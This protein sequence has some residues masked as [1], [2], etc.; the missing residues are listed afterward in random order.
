MGFDLKEFLNLNNKQK[1]QSQPQPAST[2]MPQ[3]SIVSKVVDQVNPFDNGRTFRQATPTNNRSILGQATHNMGTNVL[4]DFVG[5]PFIINPVQNVIETG[6]GISADITNNTSALNASR[7]RQWQNVKSSLPG[8]IVSNIYN[9]GKA[10]TIDLGKQ[11]IGDLTNNPVASQNANTAYMND[12]NRSAIGGLLTIPQRQL[13]QYQTNRDSPQLNDQQR[14]QVT[15]DKLQ[16]VGLDPKASLVNQLVTTGGSAIQLASPTFGLAKTAVEGTP[17]FNGLQPSYVSGATLIDQV[18]NLK[19]VTTNLVDKTKLNEVGAIG[20]D[21]R[22]LDINNNPVVN[23]KTGETLNQVVDKLKKNNWSEKDINN[24][25][26]AVKNPTRYSEI[27]K[28]NDGKLNNLNPTGTIFAEYTPKDRSIQPLGSDM[29]TVDKTIG[30]SPNDMVTVYRGVNKQ[31]NQTGIQPGDFVTTLPDLAKAYAG[32]G[33]VISLKIR[34]GD[35]LDSKSSPSLGEETIYRPGA[36]KELNIT[37]KNQPIVGKNLSDTALQSK[38][39][40]ENSI[41]IPKD[42]QLKTL[43]SDKTMSHFTDGNSPVISTNPN[44]LIPNSLSASNTGINSVFGKNKFDI[45]IPKNSKVLEVSKQSFNDMYIGRLPGEGK[46]PLEVGKAL[47]DHAVS[48]GADVIHLKNPAGM[49][50][51]WAVINKDLLQNKKP[52]I[53]SDQMGAV[54]RNIRQQDTPIVGPDLNVK[55]SR[56]AQ[57]AAK[58]SELSPELQKQIKDSAPTYQGGNNAEQIK[59]ADLLVKKGYVKATTEVTSALEKKMGT[60]TPQDT[61]NTIAVIK[62]LDKRGGTANLQKATDLTDKL[63]EHLTAAGQTVQSASL[64]S[65]RTPEGLLYGARKFLKNNGIDVTAEIQKTLNDHVNAI[66]KLSSD[67]KLNEIAKMQ[68][69]VEHLVP[70]SNL[71]KAIGIWKA[72]LLTG[73]KTQT[74]NMLSGI[75]TNV[76]KTASDAPAALLD[77]GFA[78]FGKTD[79]G[80]KMGFTGD[81]A[82]VFTMRGKGAGLVEGI[83]KGANAL[84][85]GIDE[86]NLEAGK[87]D[88]KTLVFSKKPLGRI[89]QKYTDSVYGLMGAADRPNYYSNL[90]NNLYDLALVDGKNKG[91]SGAELK[92]HV[93]DFVSNPPTKDFQTATNAAEKAIFANDTQL[94]KI[95]GGVRKAAEGNVVSKTTAGVLMPFTKVPSAVAMRIV[96][97]SPLGALKTVGEQIKNV[98]KGGVLDQRALSEGLAQAGVGTGAIWLGMQLKKN[99]LMTGSYPTDPKEQELWK[100]EGKQANSVKVNGQWQSIN[101]TSPAGQVLELGAKMQDAKGQGSSWGDTALTGAFAIPK[102][103][104]EQ[105]FLQGVQGALDATNDPGRYGSKFLKS[106]AAST[107]PTFVGDIAKS[108]DPL[109]RQSNSL[110]DAFKAKIPGLNKTLLPKQDAF[111]YPL[112]RQSSSVNTLANPFRPS[113][114]KPTTD[115]NTELRRL[116]DA[117]YGVMPTTTDKTLS[118]GSKDKGTLQNIN[119]TPKQLFDKNSQV[120][121]IVKNNWEKIIK[122]PEY[123]KMSDSEKQKVLR[124]VLSDANALGKADFAAK[125]NPALLDKTNLNKN[126][127]NLAQGNAD[128]LKTKTTEKS[129]KPKTVKTTKTKSISKSTGSK[130]SKG[131]YNFAK[132][133]TT[134]V[135]SSSELRNIVKSSKI[136]RKKVKR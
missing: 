124:N 71:D 6:R 105:S 51:E 1:Q 41:P 97:Y 8:A 69:T 40:K 65:N 5:K 134:G 115:L 29:T 128:Y 73:V 14:K 64:L 99:G 18:K 119:L 33:N 15:A 60:I 103:V 72:G 95:A 67:A 38:L 35:L 106:Q 11:V 46:T 68:N 86:R 34:K 49:G 117:Q 26:D 7:A 79:L 42:V 62:E 133:M 101:Y 48:Q 21:V 96:D 75:A 92:T 20:K 84:K 47:Y 87:F 24:Y 31:H 77:R 61:A 50:D 104:T 13:T 129:T 25:V 108:T 28:K 57:G 125:N 23:Q 112:D 78:A 55:Q 39:S 123:V 102:T 53:F 30:G 89:A 59:T 85:T 111:G 76:M 130:V 113:N 66:R 90:R 3:R 110:G 58:S 132:I 91:L 120:G 116:Q 118:F 98:K 36:H 126:Q 4:G 83:Q 45:N 88:N 32:D 135:G 122:S 80:Q 127:V 52:S 82:K 121:Q 37:N 43:S 74:G 94:S 27:I 2:A 16:Q 136:V 10:N 109:Q 100:L 93:N 114:A 131:K 9:V 63:S 54:G 44:R 107:V 12:I 81:R 17:F 19:D 70:S 56:F 22:P